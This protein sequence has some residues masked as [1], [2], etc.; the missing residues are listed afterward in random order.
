VTDAD[1]L[2]SILRDIVSSSLVE[3]KK[4]A[5]AYTGGVDSSVVAALARESAEVKCY[6]CAIEGSFD[7]A[8]ARSFAE[9]DGLELRMIILDRVELRS[10]VAEAGLMLD[11]DNPIKIAYTVPIICALEKCDEDLLLTGTGADELFAGYSKYGSAPDPLEMMN[12]DLE[13][14]LAEN[15]LLSSAAH[16]LGKTLL[17][18][19]AADRVVMFSKTIDLERKIN[20]DEKKAILREVAQLLNLES[21]MRPKKAAQYSSGVMREMERESKR[22]GTT[23][24]KWISEVCAEIRIPAERRSH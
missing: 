7:E 24:Q 17:A 3:R 18:P 14:M 1:E 6:T 16:A 11:T 5:V 23:L 8:H 21:A 13:K 20:K 2:L 10:Y 12:R 19:F 15:N 9:R 22:L 4:V